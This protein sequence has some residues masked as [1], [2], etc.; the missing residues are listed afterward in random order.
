MDSLDSPLVQHL[1]TSWQAAFL[2]YVFANHV[3]TSSGGGLSP[4]PSVPQH[5][6]LNV[7][8]YYFLLFVGLREDGHQK[9]VFSLSINAAKL[10]LLIDRF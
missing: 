2:I 8:K 9:I 6:T 4:Q 10:F 5:N 3:P 7:L 1:L